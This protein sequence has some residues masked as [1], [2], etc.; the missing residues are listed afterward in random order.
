[1]RVPGSL[2]RLATLEFD[3]NAIAGEVKELD[4]SSQW[5]SSMIQPTIFLVFIGLACYV[6]YSS[7]QKRAN[8]KRGVPSK[9]L[10]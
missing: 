9:H 6:S 5:L 8:S 3:S 1:M 7:V 10:P 4:E 2:T